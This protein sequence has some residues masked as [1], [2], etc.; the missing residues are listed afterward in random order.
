MV[1]L[2]REQISEITLSEKDSIWK[3]K[4]KLSGFLVEKMF[5]EEKK[6]VVENEDG[7]LELIDYTDELCSNIR[8][9][10][11]DFHDFEMQGSSITEISEDCVLEINLEDNECRIFPGGGLLFFGRKIYDGGAAAVSFSAVWLQGG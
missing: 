4:Q 5:L 10:E 2:E 7:D 11:G 1:D 3:Q 8:F 9:P 6:A